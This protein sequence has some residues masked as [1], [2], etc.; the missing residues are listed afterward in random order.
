[1]VAG[2]VIHNGG[3]TPTQSNAITRAVTFTNVNTKPHAYGIT[4]SNPRTH[5]V[6]V[7]DAGPKANG[8]TYTVTNSHNNTYYNTY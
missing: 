1:M 6:T 7:A 3:C 4:H 8:N 2:V 5:A